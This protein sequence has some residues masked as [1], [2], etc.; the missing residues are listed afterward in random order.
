MRIG[1]QYFDTTTSEMAAIAL[2]TIKSTENPEILLRVR[3][4]IICIVS[5]FRRICFK[6]SP[7]IA[8]NI[9]L[10]PQKVAASCSPDFP[11][12]ERR[13]SS[14]FKTKKVRKYPRKTRERFMVKLSMASVSVVWYAPTGSL[15]F[16]G[17]IPLLISLL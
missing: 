11:A 9:K 12:K 17:W 6:R 8:A 13:K 3:L 4:S 16:L 15:L 10:N 2:V 1:N 7:I 5:V 14:P